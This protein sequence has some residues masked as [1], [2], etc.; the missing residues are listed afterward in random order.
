[1]KIE[2]HNL[3]TR[4]ITHI[5]KTDL[6]LLIYGP[7]IF[8]L[9]LFSMVSNSIIWIT[10]E[11]ISDLAL[12]IVGSIA[13]FIA[14]LSGYFQIIRRETPGFFGKYMKGIPSVING[15]GVMVFSWLLSIVLIISILH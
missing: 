12:G 13:L 2:N 1:M 10:H 6:F 14:G 15:F 11:K 4:I 8:G 7:I 9:L 5:K 3:K